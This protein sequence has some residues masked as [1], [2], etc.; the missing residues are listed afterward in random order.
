MSAECGQE[1]GNLAQLLFVLLFLAVLPVLEEI[2]FEGLLLLVER[3]RLVKHLDALLSVLDVVVEHVRVLVADEFAAVFAVNVL[4]LFRPNGVDGAGSA[5][6]GLD[7]R[8]RDIHGNEPDEDLCLVLFWLGYFRL[9]VERRNFGLRLRLL[10]LVLP[11]LMLHRLLLLT[12]VLPGLGV[13]VSVQNDVVSTD[14]AILTF[15]E[16]TLRLARI[17]EVQIAVPFG[18][19][20]LVEDDS[21]AFDVI[22]VG[23]EVVAKLMLG[24]VAGEV[25]DVQGAGGIE[26]V[27]HSLLRRTVPLI[28]RVI[29]LLVH[30][31][32][33][34]AVV[35][36]AI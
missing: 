31:P 4:N 20:L 5:E 2:D 3:H 7:F 9:R 24:R 1:M 18:A 13:P 6:L 23:V 29:A 34:E 8:F 16:A 25:T 14:D 36:P 12:L 11:V 30:A 10:T 33:T 15:D 32:I 21:G 26:T 22:A 35:L 28:P 17:C 27:L 19:A